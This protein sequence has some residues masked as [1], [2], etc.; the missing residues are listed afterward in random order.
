[1]SMFNFFSKYDKLCKNFSFKNF[2]IFVKP[3]HLL[4]TS[5]V[6]SCEHVLEV[7]SATCIVHVGRVGE[8]PG[9]DNHVDDHE[10]DDDD[11]EG[12]YEDYE[13]YADHF[14]KERVD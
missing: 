8:V 12:E 11:D 3:F 10:G 6:G 2:S 13:D 7:Q 5:S 14:G 4:E 1:M 9:E